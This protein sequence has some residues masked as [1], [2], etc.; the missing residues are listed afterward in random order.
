M[1]QVV[2]TQDS[3]KTE[4]KAELISTS[5]FAEPI[6]NLPKGLKLTDLV[7]VHTEKFKVS[8]RNPEP[9]IDFH[10]YGLARERADKLEVPYV[11][12]HRLQGD[13]FVSTYLAVFYDLRNK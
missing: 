5:R 2:K 10:A 11:G 8:E 3:K 6:L 13:N 7:Q 12:V 1:N 9:M 4:P